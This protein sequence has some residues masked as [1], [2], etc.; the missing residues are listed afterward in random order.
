MVSAINPCLQI[1]K[2]KVDHWQVLFGLFRVAT[3]D[4]RIVLIA[5]SGEIVERW[6]SVLHYP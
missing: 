3:E 4:K 6:N 5:H 2:D 1:R